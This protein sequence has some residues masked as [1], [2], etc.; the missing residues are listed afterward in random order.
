ML[1]RL[2]EIT[3]QD[4]SRG[5]DRPDRIALAQELLR[6]DRILEEDQATRAQEDGEGGV[7][8]AAEER[9]TVARR[10][11]DAEDRWMEEERQ[12]EERT[13]AMDQ[14]EGAWQR[15]R[16]DAAEEGA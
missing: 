10:E 4:F 2:D 8:D 9:E 5:Y 14:E 13:A 1:K 11:Q 6:L 7:N 3:S 15:A 16:D 12:D